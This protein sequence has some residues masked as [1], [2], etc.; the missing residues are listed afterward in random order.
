MRA[1]KGRCT[2]TACSRESCTRRSL[3]NRIPVDTRRSPSASN[4]NEVRSQDSH[5]KKATSA[6]ARS[7]SRIRPTNGMPCPASTTPASSGASA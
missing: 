7:T 5:P 3:R 6:R 1:T 2:S 4:Q